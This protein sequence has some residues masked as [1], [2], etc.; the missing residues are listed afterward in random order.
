MLPAYTCFSVPAAAVAAGLRVR[1]VDVTAEGRIDAEAL[2][3]L[4]LER[5]AAV[6][7]CNLFG[8]AEPLAPIARATRE[9][10]ARLVDDAAQAFG[11]EASDGKAG[12][13]GD[14]GILSFGRGKPLSA[15]GGGALVVEQ[16]GGAEPGPQ[17]TPGGRLRALASALAYDAALSPRVFGWLAAVPGLG[18][19]ETPFEPQFAR[20]GIS[21]GRGGPGAGRAVAHGRRRPAPA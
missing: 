6:V 20:G 1:L 2:A 16:T 9:A 11:A 14:L 8:F 17:P 15:L 3:K 5:A 12:G 21:H 4:P 18:I 13:R 19:G 7:A 10:G